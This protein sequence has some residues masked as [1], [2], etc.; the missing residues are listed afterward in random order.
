MLR[1]TRSEVN[2]L[3]GRE[4]APSQAPAPAAPAVDQ[5][6]MQA[7]ADSSRAMA[8][9]VQALVADRARPRTL[10]AVIHRDDKGR[11]LRVVATIV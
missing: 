8:D 11:M 1:M 2:K 4:P 3:A 6:P 9:A 10:E 5:A 7:I